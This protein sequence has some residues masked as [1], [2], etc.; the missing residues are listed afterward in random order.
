MNMSQFDVK[1]VKLRPLSS[2][3]TTTV[4]DGINPDKAEEVG[5]KVQMQLDG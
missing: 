3:L 2:G 4:G 1:E 5:F